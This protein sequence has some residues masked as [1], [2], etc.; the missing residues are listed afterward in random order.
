VEGWVGPLFPRGITVT[1]RCKEH[2]VG[3]EFEI[4]YFEW[5]ARMDVEEYYGYT[6]EDSA[7]VVQVGMESGEAGDGQGLL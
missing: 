5:G 4:R 1:L 6:K 7:I 2:D 3:S